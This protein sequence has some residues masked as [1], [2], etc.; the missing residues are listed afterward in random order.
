MER[1]GV[2]L[3]ESPMGSAVKVFVS[4]VLTLAVASWAQDGVLSFDAWQTWV[5]A[6]AGAALPVIVNW[7]NPADARYGVGSGPQFYA[8]TDG[9]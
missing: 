2:W 1:F 9:E 4:V 3:A 8:D 5:I 7:L 6:A